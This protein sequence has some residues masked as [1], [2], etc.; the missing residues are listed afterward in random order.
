MGVNG[1]S[2]QVP[3]VQ[4]MWSTFKQR[5]AL[6]GQQSQKFLKRYWWG[7]FPLAIVAA[8]TAAIVY[9]YGAYNQIIVKPTIN[10]DAQPQEASPSPPDPL[11]PISILLMGYGGGNHAGGLLT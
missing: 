8:M 6:A 4:Q 5:A 7:F 3:S 2:H 10:P 1:M 11:R 9:G